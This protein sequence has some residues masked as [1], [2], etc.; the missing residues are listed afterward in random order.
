MRKIK[1]FN[2]ING[3]LLVMFSVLACSG[4]NSSTTESESVKIVVSKEE[5]R[6]DLTYLSSDELMGR[7][8]GTEGIEDAAKFIEEKFKE[9]GV[10][11]Y[12]ETYRDNFMVN[13]VQGFNILGV[14]E[15]SD[16]ELKNEYIIIGAHYD[17]IG[18]AKEVEGDTIANG[19][20]DNAAGTVGVIHLAKHFSKNSDNK[21]SII[22]ALFSGEEMGLRG[23]KHLAEKLKADGLDLYVMFNLEMIGVPMKAKDYQ[24]YLTGFEKSNLAEKFNTYSEGDKVLGFLPQAQQMSLFQRS[25][26]YPFF[27]EF[28]VPSQTVSTFDFSNYPYYH[29]VDDESQFLDPDFMASLIEDLIPG[30]SKMANTAEKEIKMKD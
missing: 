24:A 18:T 11:P 4:Q 17:H 2:R 29:H 15:G 12:F 27:Q 5:V 21:R 23:S 13:D 3:M 20:N 28:N 22:F 6:E 10:K 7:K 8:T 16:P 19:A 25:D 9:F 1:I 14:V 30:L 26:N